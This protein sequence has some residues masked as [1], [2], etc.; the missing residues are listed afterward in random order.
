[1]SRAHVEVVLEALAAALHDRAVEPAE[2]SE[3]S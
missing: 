2:E 1:M 3:K